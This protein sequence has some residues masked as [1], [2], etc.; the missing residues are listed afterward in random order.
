ME[1]AIFPGYFHGKCQRDGV[2]PP[3]CP[4]PDCPVVCGTPGSLVHFYSKLRFIAFNATKHML[5]ESAR[6]AYNNIGGAALANQHRSTA[7]MSRI[8]RTM[9]KKRDDDTKQILLSI[10]SLLEKICGGTGTGTT[11][12]LPDCSWEKGMKAF[13]LSFP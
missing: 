3:G 9:F 7:R 11:N 1:N 4:N 6:D 12:G 10:A 8:S 2:E 5:E 13:I